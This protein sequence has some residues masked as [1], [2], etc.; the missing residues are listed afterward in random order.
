MNPD[1]LHYDGHDLEGLSAL[2]L[3]PDWIVALFAPYI[4]GTVIEYGA[5][6]GAISTRLR[7]LAE[8]LVLV[9]PSPHQC[10]ELRAR[11]AGDA[12]V[13]TEQVPLERHI[14][15]LADRNHDCAVL[16]NVLEHIADD[17]MALRELARILRPSGTLLLFV[18]ALPFLFSKMD[19]VLGHYRRYRRDELAD[20]VVASGF[21]VISARYMDFL[22]VAPWWLLNTLGGVV[23]FNPFL[24][25]LY[26][27]VG[28]P[29][30][31]F[32]ENLLPT[33]PFGKNVLL[34]ARKKP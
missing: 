32:I 6:A 34:I 26:D 9:E 11:F 25:R 2:S 23:K 24:A 10:V 21:E 8:T 31:R 7:P 15:A 14:A 29:L 16:V 30:T 1:A 33:V 28:V 4:R 13:M 22:G 3:Y 18:P 12:A 19:T 27:S 17:G 5:G 20:L